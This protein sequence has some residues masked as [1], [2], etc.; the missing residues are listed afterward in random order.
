MGDVPIFRKRKQLE[1]GKS[2]QKIS[3]SPIF[4]KALPLSFT[5]GTIASS[6]STSTVFRFTVSPQIPPGNSRRLAHIAKL[7]L[8]ISHSSS[9]HL[10]QTLSPRYT[11]AFFPHRKNLQFWKH[12]FASVKVRTIHFETKVFLKEMYS[13]VLCYG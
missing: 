8:D 4:R 1:K 12:F 10:H 6:G 5:T 13:L 11:V 3:F 2:R 7:Q 9:V